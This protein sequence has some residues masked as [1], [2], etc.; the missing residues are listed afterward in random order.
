MIT[1]ALQKIAASL[2]ISASFAAI[3]SC[4]KKRIPYAALGG[5]LTSFINILILKNINGHFIPLMICA[6]FAVLYAEY[7]AVKLKAPATIFVMPSVLPL[8]PGRWLYRAVHSLVSGDTN[9]FFDYLIKTLKIS[10]SIAFGI[11]AAGTVVYY[12][13]FIHSKYECKKTCTDYGSVD[14]NTP[15]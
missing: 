1:S 15:L 3:Y 14:K 9:G 4:E 7:M 12:V 13:K 5:G 8:M 10:F 2:I 11:L 6:G